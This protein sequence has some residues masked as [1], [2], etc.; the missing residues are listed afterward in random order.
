MFGGTPPQQFPDGSMLVSGEQMQLHRTTEFLSFALGVPLMLW[1]VTRK[2]PLNTQEKVA[3]GTLAI[4]A[5]LVD[6]FLWFRFHKA[7]QDAVAAP[8]TL[9]DLAPGSQS[10]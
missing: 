2:R 3:L 10:S 5:L 4:G 6:G 8:P 9:A 7:R 1:I